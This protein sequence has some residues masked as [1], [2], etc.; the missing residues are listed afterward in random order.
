MADMMGSGQVGAPPAV[1]EVPASEGRF[2][3]ELAED[4]DPALDVVEVS[5]EAREETIELAPGHR[6]RMWTY[7]GQLPGPRIEA[8]A[9]DT[10]RVHFKNSLPETTTIHWHGIRV[11]A[12]MDGV[13]AAQS[14]VEPNGEFTYEFVVPDAG[15]FWY[16]PHIRSDEQVER[17]L[18]GAFIVRAENEPTTT[19]ERVVVLDDLLVD[20][21]WMPLGLDPMQAMVGRQGNLILANGRAHPVAEIERGG[22]HRFRFVNA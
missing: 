18:Y 2:E 13:P 19:T 8:R 22:L 17:G 7:N 15:T 5:L 11:P 20:S 21:D 3:G 1:L 16:H 12:A 4:L 10:V 14:P 6:V 9:G